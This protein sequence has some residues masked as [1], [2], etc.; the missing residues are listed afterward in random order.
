MRRRMM[1]SLFGCPVRGSFR[2]RA[3]RVPLVS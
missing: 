2:S 1:I 3:R